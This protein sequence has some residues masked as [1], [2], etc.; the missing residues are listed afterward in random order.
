MDE[1]K[2]T[3]FE[4]GSGLEYF[5][6]YKEVVHHYGIITAAVFSVIANYSKYSMSGEKR[7]SIKSEV[8]IGNELQLT[9]TLVRKSIKILLE[10]ELIEK[11]NKDSLSEEKTFNN[12]NWYRPISKNVYLLKNKERKLFPKSNYQRQRSQEIGREKTKE[13]KTIKNKN[14]K[15]KEK[16]NEEINKNINQNIN[17]TDEYSW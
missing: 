2:E 15:N 8:G 17:E 9:W 13:N 6:I 10:D 4:E 5:K 12:A 1:N 14:K 3:Y 11:V 16:N 7:C